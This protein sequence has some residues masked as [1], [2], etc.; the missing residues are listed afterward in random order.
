[1]GVWRQPPFLQGVSAQAKDDYRKI[2]ENE[3]MAKEQLTNAIAA[4]AAKNN[5]NPQVAAFNDKQ[6]QKLKKQRAAITSAVQK[7]PAVLNQCSWNRSR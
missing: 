4:W 1:Y 6:D 3:V 7:L 5:V 2:Y